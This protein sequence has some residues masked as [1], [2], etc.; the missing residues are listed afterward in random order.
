MRLDRSGKTGSQSG[1]APQNSL[2][3]V[4]TVRWSRTLSSDERSSIWNR[5]NAQVGRKR[6]L[7]SFRK[8]GPTN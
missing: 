4:E 2:R 1:R 5:S 7:I 8:R 6:R 3:A